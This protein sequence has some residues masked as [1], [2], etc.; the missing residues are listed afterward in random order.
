MHS[1]STESDFFVVI[2]QN[3]SIYE[4]VFLSINLL[5]MSESSSISLTSLITLWIGLIF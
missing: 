2:C 4:V 3:L 1:D 5:R